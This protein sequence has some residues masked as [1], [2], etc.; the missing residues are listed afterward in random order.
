MRIPNGELWRPRSLFGHS[1]FVILSTFVI[2]ISSLSRASLRRL[3]QVYERPQIRLPPIGEEPRLHRGGRGVA[4][5]G[6]RRQHHDLQLRQRAPAPAASRRGAGKVMAGL[7]AEPEG[8][9]RIFALPRSE[10]PGLRLF[11]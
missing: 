1:S 3:L 11:P 10:L 4:G 2:R 8:D 9:L 5:P 7:A 6:Y